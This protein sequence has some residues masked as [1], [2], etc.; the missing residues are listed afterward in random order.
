[1]TA[2]LEDLLHNGLVAYNLSGI[3]GDVT[4]SALPPDS[5]VVTG[6]DG[7][8][9]L[10]LFLYQATPNQGWRN[11]DL[12]SRDSRGDRISNPPLALNL[13]YL[14]TAYGTRELFPEI[15]LGHGMQ[16][17]HD[18]PVL[19]RDA[20]RKALSPTAPPADFP[21]ALATSDLAEQLEQLKITPEPMNTEEISKLWTALQASY[22]PTAAYQVTVV[23]MQTRRSSRSALPVRARN[24]YVVPF[25]QPVIERVVSEDG[26]DVPITSKS[27]IL[28]QGER[29]RAPG[30]RVF[31]GGFDLT[32]SAIFSETEVKITLPPTLPDGLHAGLHP[33]QVVHPTLMGT[34]PVEHSGVESNVAALL[35]RPTI[36][37]SPPTGT[38]VKVDFTP[39]VGRKQRVRLLL[40][41]LNPP[42]DRPARAYT[43][44]APKDNGV[45]D[46]AV[47]TG[48]ITFS[49]EDID[50][51]SYL[52]RVQVDGAESLLDVDS[53]GVF[54]DPQV[55]VP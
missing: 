1:V 6:Q 10:N 31:A 48:S 18:N 49:C 37:L 8:N 13:H 16:L 26:D 46:P 15:L 38:T 29:L 40:N 55:T 12:P 35:L 52:A 3:L 34:P 44:E 21:T 19:A 2:V 53:N 20:I 25:R 33:F 7:G 30:A 14:L 27:T 5:S 39:K 17:F 45:V 42:A 23:L 28:I 24:V 32:A 4:V 22:R 9:R 41:E 36:A 47:D 50:K 11:V 54:V 43:V 51:G